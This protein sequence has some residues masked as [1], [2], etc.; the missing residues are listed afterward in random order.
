MHAR[1]TPCTARVLALSVNS[2]LY[3]I[4]RIISHNYY[5]NPSVETPNLY[6]MKLLAIIQPFFYIYMQGNDVAYVLTALL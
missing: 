6:D 2:S 1:L 3:N 5:A 4:L